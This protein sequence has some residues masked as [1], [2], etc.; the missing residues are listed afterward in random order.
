MPVPTKLPLPAHVYRTELTTSFRRLTIR[1]GVLLE[2]PAGW[3]EVS[4]FS[5]YGTEESATWLKAALETAYLGFPDPV[6]G[7][8]PVNVTVP[9]TSPE[10]AARIVTRGGC[11]TAKIKVAEA[12]Q[13]PGDDLARVRAVREVFDGKIRLDANGAWDRDD[14]VTMIARLDEAAGGLEYVE[15]PS[16]TPEDLAY[17][18]SRVDVPIAADE[19]IR[20]SG[21]PF[22]VAR[23]G[24][25]D[26]IVAKVQPLGGIRACLRLAE[27]LGMAVV[28]SSALES[29]VGIAAGVALGACLPRLD[30]ACGLA[31]VQLFDQDVSQTPLVPRDGSLPLGVPPVTLHRVDPALEREWADRLDAMWEHLQRT[32]DVSELTGGAL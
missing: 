6:R 13:G 3:A 7:T 5:E 22:K 24:A 23:L 18:R 10:R 20:K 28:V 17:V 15:Q 14:A 19:S 21:D 8:V 25:A 4:P 12:G 27:E 29:S 31:T 30:H 32:T 16:P 11:H 26:L 2:G 9:A 1:T